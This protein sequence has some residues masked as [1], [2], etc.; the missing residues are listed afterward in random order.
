MTAQQK[1]AAMAVDRLFGL[2]PPQDVGDPEA[3]LAATIAMFSEHAPEIMQKA[4]F[5]I[6]KR[7]DRPTL[8][9][10]A[11]VFSE[12]DDR[13]RE[14]EQVTNRLP[15]PIERPRTPEEQERANAQVAE[16]RRAFG[17]PPE[18]LRRAG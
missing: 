4:A 11:Q 14:R 5:E 9:M 15:P 17:L 8:H 18:G 10:M 12:L 16:V 1:Q 6:P 3:F 13:A 2:L 7:S